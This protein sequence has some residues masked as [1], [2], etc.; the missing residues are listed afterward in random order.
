MDLHFDIKLAEGY[1]SNSQRARVMTEDWMTRNMYCPICGQS[2]VQHFEAN[3]PVADFF[4]SECKAEYEL[5]S[6]S[7][8]FG[9]LINDGEYHKMIYR[10][11][12]LNNPNFFFMAY[13]DYTVTNLILVPRFF[14]TPNIIIKR[15][16]LSQNARRAGWTGCNID[17]S[18]VPS[19]GRIFIVKDKK[20]VDEEQVLRSYAK[21]IA[22]QTDNMKSR[23]WLMDT[24]KCVDAIVGDTFCLDD[25]YSFE[26]ILKA[27]HP[28]N[29]FIKDKLRQQLQ[30][31]RD[32]G[33][34]EFLGR[35]HYRKLK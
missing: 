31:L 20:V 6:I 7:G 11:T 35:G 25:I 19:N 4:C 2:H 28:D 1:H 10:I 26:K 23:G 16:P 24:M 18:A 13:D 14:F 9:R 32:K 5:K 29:N 33:F 8:S 34:V 22:L 27:K 12:S 17:I 15:K 21:T 3:R 30:M